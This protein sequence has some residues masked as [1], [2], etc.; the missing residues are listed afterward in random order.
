LQNGQ[1]DKMQKGE[2]QCH[3]CGSNHP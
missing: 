3:N 2:N 1:W